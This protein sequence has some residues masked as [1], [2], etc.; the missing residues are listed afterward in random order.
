MKKEV[1]QVNS[2]ALVYMLGAILIF[3]GWF[4]GITDYTGLFMGLGI[5]TA[6]V[7]LP[8]IY[9]LLF[10][11]LL[12]VGG[13]TTA[14]YDELRHPFTRLYAHPTCDRFCA[15]ME[16]LPLLDWLLGETRPEEWA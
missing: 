4:L 10:L 13:Y 7:M 5:I 15:F 11:V 14:L 1:N 9:V 2:A 8:I 16:K 3:A 12:L 6:G